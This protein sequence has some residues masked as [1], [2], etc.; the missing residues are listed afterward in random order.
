MLLVAGLYQFTPLKC[1]CL[2]HCRSPRTFIAGPWR[3]REEQHQSYL[4]GVL[5]GIIC[6]GCCWTLMLLMFLV[7][8]GSLFWMLLLGAVMAIEKTATWGHQLSAPLGISLMS[9]GCAISLLAVH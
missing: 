4:L 5:H 1:H 6:V 2:K 3:G 8:A 9:A 7:G